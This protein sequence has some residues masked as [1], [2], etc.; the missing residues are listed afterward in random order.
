MRQNWHSEKTIPGLYAGAQSHAGKPVAVTGM[1]MVTAIG[2]GYPA[3]WEAALAGQSGFSPISLFES[4]AYR[5]HIAAEVRNFDFQQFLTSEEISHLGRQ[6][7]MAL[8]SARMAVAD[9][10]IELKRENPERIGC[11]MGLLEGEPVLLQK[12]AKN[13]AEGTP[14]AVMSPKPFAYPWFSPAAVLARAFGLKG[15]CQSIHCACASGNYA[16]AWGC[17]Q[18]RQGYTDMVLVGGAEAFN[19]A[20]FTGFHHWRSLAPQRCQPF[21]KG[22]KGLIVGEGAAVMVLEPL[23]TALAAGRRIHAQVLGHGLSCDAYHLTAPHPRGE[24]AIRATRD[25]LEDAGLAPDQIDYVS[26]HG[27]GTEANDRIETLALKEVFGS[28]SRNLRISSL[29]SMIGHCMGAAS[30]IGAV[31]CC[32]TVSRDQVPPTMN[33]D[34]PDPACDLN[35]TANEAV[36]VPVRLAMN[37]AFG[38]GG[39]NGVVIFGKYEESKPCSRP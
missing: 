15:P 34:D 24:G 38:F 32:L 19:Q 39:V 5:C 21:C 20:S 11:A 29:K 18:I 33:L 14:P 23:E 16:L 22:R 13:L 27:T 35:Y 4:T 31:A 3:F 2:T 37:N 26:A 28:H 30:A 17:E 10:G 25:A 12:F 1:G 8:A 9:A 7:G 36:S 6:V